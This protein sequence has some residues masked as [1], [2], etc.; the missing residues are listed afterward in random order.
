M[1]PINLIDCSLE[2]LVAALLHE[3]PIAILEGDPSFILENDDAR[4]ILAYY[5]R[6]RD[7][8]PRAKQVQAREIEEVLKALEEDPPVKPPPARR[9]GSVAGVRGACVCDGWGLNWLRV[10]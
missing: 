10:G 1:S 7:L 8:W 4:R 9:S 5:A 6:R 3:Q 2:D